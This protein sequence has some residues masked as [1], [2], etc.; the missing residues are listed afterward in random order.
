[1]RFPRGTE[2]QEWTKARREIKKKR[3]HPH[4][5]L[6]K[7]EANGF[8]THTPHR[9]KDVLMS[10]DPWRFPVQFAQSWTIVSA[11]PGHL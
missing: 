11:Q 4:F 10:R 3:I 6:N 1:M 2:I 5:L 7:S 9:H 8:C